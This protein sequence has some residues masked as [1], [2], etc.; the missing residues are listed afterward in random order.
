MAFKQQ[1]LNQ[2][3]F[4]MKIIEDLG[5]TTA[6]DQTTK[7]ARYAIFECTKC[8]K[9]F[10][11]RATGS[12]A[13]KQTCCVECTLNKKQT[14]KHP[15]YAIWNGIRQRCYNPKRKDYPKYGGKGITMH[16]DW[17]DNYEF[18]MDYCLSNGWSSDKVID[19]DIKCK[20][21]NIDPPI[22]SPDTLSFITTQQNAEEANAKAVLQ[23]DKEGNFIA[24]HLSCVKAVISLDKP[25]SAKSSIA[26]CCR[27][28]SKT[29]FGFM[30]KYK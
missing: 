18:F 21:L 8:K 17:V 23:Y 1:T 15:L 24:E 9:H 5:Q 30:W 16:K 3:E 27:G 12:V 26:N 11:A 10:K 25:Y 2:E 7:K 6:N 14:Y 28:L 19:K 20:K 4:S 13:R 29:S 22:Y